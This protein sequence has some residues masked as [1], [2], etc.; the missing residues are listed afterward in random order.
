MKYRITWGDGYSQTTSTKKEAL[1][2]AS[3]LLNSGVTVIITK[4]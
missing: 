1:E 2:I 3:D 4:L